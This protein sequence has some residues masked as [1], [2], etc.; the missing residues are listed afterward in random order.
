MKM[1]KLGL[2]SRAL[3]ARKSPANARAEQWQGNFAKW[4]VLLE[5]IVPRA[6]VRMLLKAAHALSFIG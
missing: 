1:R 2:V 5:E 3:Q 6:L 4:G